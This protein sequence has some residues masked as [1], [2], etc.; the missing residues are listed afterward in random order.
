MKTVK[1]DNVKYPYYLYIGKQKIPV[2][3]QQKFKSEFIRKHG[4]SI[5]G[6]YIGLRFLGKKWTMKRCLSY[7]RK[8][9]SPKAKFTIRDCGKAMRAICGSERV[10]V[11]KEYTKE[12]LSKWLL[13][14]NMLIFEEADPIHTVVLY[15]SAVMY[16]ISSGKITRTTLEKEW[17]K[18]C[19]ASVY[20]GVIVC[21]TKN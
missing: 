5:V 19:R 11:H 10:S 20:E 3:K 12:Q 9:Y 18:R 6:M 14:G 15:G 17:K 2:P 8:H 21:R 1:R 16:R 7:M 13:Q 4:C